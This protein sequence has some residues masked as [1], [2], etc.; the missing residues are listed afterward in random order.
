MHTP[1]FS[2]HTTYIQGTN[3]TLA[4]VSFMHK[5]ARIYIHANNRWSCLEQP[6]PVLRRPWRAPRR[7]CRAW[8]SRA[9][10]LLL[11]PTTLHRLCVV[12]SSVFVFACLIV[13]VHANDFPRTYHH[14]RMHV[15][16][17]V[18]AHVNKHVL[19]GVMYR[20][21]GRVPATGTCHVSALVGFT[22]EVASTWPPKPFHVC[23]LDSAIACTLSSE[24]WV[25]VVMIK[26]LLM[27]VYRKYLKRHVRHAMPTEDG[28]SCVGLG[29]GPWLDVQDHGARRVHQAR[30]GRLF[31]CFSGYVFVCVY[32]Y[33]NEKMRFVLLCVFACTCV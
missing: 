10:S 19:C 17:R 21:P 2:Q 13:Y 8:L 23:Q 1:A 15:L 30:H 3:G 12:K 28:A 11:P 31:G 24:Q 7:S 32:V 29:Q 27:C 5:Q 20:S 9:I 18:Y 22:C 25:G 4:L 16:V 26:R 6:C 14:A 33:V